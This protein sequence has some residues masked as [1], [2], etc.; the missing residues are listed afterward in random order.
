MANKMDELTN[1]YLTHKVASETNRRTSLSATGGTCHLQPR[2]MATMKKPS[3]SHTYK[4]GAQPLLLLDRATQTHLPITMVANRMPS[5]SL[6][7]EFLPIRLALSL[8]KVLF[9]MAQIPSI[10]VKLAI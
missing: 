4:P 6:A 2:P 5:V 8:V 1:D 3:V 7:A 10:G 9:L